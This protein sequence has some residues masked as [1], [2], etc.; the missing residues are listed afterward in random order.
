MTD[1]Q[2][3]PIINTERLLLRDIRISDINDMFEYASHDIITQYVLWDTHNSPN[4][5]MVFINLTLKEYKTGNHYDWGIELKSNGK[6]I[7][8]VGFPNMDIKNRNA[9]LGFVVSQDYCGKG[10]ATEAAKAV[11]EFGF[12]ELKLHRIWAEHFQDNNA[13]KKVIQKLGMIYEGTMRESVCKNNVFHNLLFH[14]I[15]E[16]KEPTRS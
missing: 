12:E 14:S 3:F 9:E 15:L 8:T 4:D 11:L 5:S 10:I 6:F 13:S 16:K 7:G 1:N 2:S